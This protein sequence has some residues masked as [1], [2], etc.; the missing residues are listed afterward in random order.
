[1]DKT[2]AEVWTDAQQE[3][4]EYLGS[5]FTGLWSFLRRSEQAEM[6]QADFGTVQHNDLAR[7]A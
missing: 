5:I 2:F 7:A 4:S 3:R 1:M 6:P